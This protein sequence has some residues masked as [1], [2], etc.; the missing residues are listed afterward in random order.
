MAS[1]QHEPYLA[2]DGMHV[3]TIAHLNAPGGGT[4]EGGTGEISSRQAKERCQ[5]M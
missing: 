3:L 1:S 5:G 2:E 4:Y